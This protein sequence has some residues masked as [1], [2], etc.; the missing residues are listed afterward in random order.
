MAH[1]V[2]ALAD[3]DLYSHGDPH[4]A[5]AHLRRECPVSWQ[6]QAGHEPFWAVT[7]YEPGVEV[8]TDWRRFS[9]ANGTTLRPN[10]SAPF[11]GGGTMLV[12]VDPPR[13]TTLRRAISSL[14]TPRAVTRLEPGMR[15]V[16]KQLLRR[17]ARAGRCDFA[18]DVAKPYPVAVTAELLGVPATDVTRICAL[19]SAVA[20]TAHDLDGTAARIAHLEVLEY[21]ASVIARR[22]AYPGGDFVSALTAMQAAGHS[23]TDEEIILACDNVV[24]AASETT[25]Y[26][27][28]AGL[29]ALLENPAQ[30]QALRRGEIGF[31]AVV[32]EIL[33]WAM[34]VNHI[35]RTAVTRTRLLDR[36]ILPGQHVSVWVP[37]MNRDEAVFDAADQFDASRSPN[38]HMSFGGGA[39]FCLGAHVARQS[40]RVLLEEL[41][42]VA[43]DISLAGP[44]QRRASY[45]ANDI[46]SLPVELR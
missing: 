22:R 27:I 21:Y 17:A 2:P 25:Q 6:D 16:A 46:S 4:A 15:S 14:F 32:E 34:P 31:G 29:L 18:R 1:A 30:L 26:A 9:S 20:R 42:S 37:S 36:D 8:L 11:P 35:M 39:H 43:G 12:L 3:P 38:R 24:V 41:T 19:T 13:H 10:L 23:I 40:I 45:V 28:S 7:T 33:R 44:P 5:W